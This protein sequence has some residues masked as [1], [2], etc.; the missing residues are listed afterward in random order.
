MLS[1]SAFDIQTMNRKISTLQTQIKEKLDYDVFDNQ[2]ENIILVIA[3]ALRSGSQAEA[4]Q[5][6]IDGF[7]EQARNLPDTKLLMEEHAAKTPDKNKEARPKQ[8]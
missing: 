2:I 8:R 6:D 4:H 1:V 3:D 5:I 7:K